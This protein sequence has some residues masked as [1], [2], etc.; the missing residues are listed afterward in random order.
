M[1]KAQAAH[2]KRHSI[3]RMRA[4]ASTSTVKSSSKK[5]PLAF[6]DGPMVWIDCEVCARGGNGQKLL[7]DMDFARILLGVQMTGLDPNKD[8]I[9]EISVLI[10][11]GDLELVDEEGISFII[12]TDKEHLDNMDEWCVKQHGEVCRSVVFFRN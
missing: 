7:I 11:N 12:K 3:F 2:S 10:T 8:R 6:S 4:N 9:L 5:P 1:A